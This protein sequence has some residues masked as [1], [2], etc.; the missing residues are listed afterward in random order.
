MTDTPKPTLVEELR[1]LDWWT[2]VDRP[3]AM[4]RVGAIKV[5]K[6][7]ESR[8]F[9][10]RAEL[11]LCS[12]VL[13]NTVEELRAEIKYHEAER[14]K[15][16][17]ELEAFRALA[18]EAADDDEPDVKTKTECWIGWRNRMTRRHKALAKLAEETKP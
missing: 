17:A 16:V 6:Q 13:R 2:E 18:R 12:L 15:L 11:Q 9:A 8:W 4:D 3:N 10:E 5:A 1:T 7:H 14:A